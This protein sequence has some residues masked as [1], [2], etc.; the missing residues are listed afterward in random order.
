[1]SKSPSKQPE[2]VTRC[3]GCGAVLKS[4]ASMTLH[5]PE[6]CIVLRNRRGIA[7]KCRTPLVRDCRACPVWLAMKEEK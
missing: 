1:M 6:G 4:K 5:D 2:P 3:P 7:A